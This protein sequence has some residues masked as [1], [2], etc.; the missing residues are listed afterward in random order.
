MA[1]NTLEAGAEPGADLLYIC[2]KQTNT[3]MTS[4]RLFLDLR[5]KSKD[6]KGLLIT[7][8]P[9]PSLLVFKP[10]ESVL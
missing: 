8:V 1:Y 4:T 2:L 7:A 3:Y 5:G 6:G 10:S 9:V